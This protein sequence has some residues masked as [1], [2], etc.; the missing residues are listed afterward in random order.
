M[1]GELGCLTG[2]GVLLSGGVGV[3]VLYVLPSLAVK[4]WQVR[5]D[6]RSSAV[7]VLDVDKIVCPITG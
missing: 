5:A 4:V 2:E 7:I 1:L 6:F 3:G